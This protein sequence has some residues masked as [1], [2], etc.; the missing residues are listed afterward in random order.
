MITAGETAAKSNLKQAAGTFSTP[1]SCVTHTNFTLPKQQAP[2]PG[3]VQDEEG[4][5]RDAAH[6]DRDGDDGKVEDHPGH[7]R[8]DGGVQT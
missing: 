4:A 5:D 6:L 1:F 2:Q 8:Q 3:E 7:L